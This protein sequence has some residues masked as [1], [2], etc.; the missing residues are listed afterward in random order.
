MVGIAHPVVPEEPRPCG[1][2]A[3]AGPHVDHP[4]RHAE[5]ARLGAGVLD[6]HV[7]TCVVVHRGGDGTAEGYMP[8]AGYPDRRGGL[9]RA[10]YGKV[11]VR[12]DCRRGHG[13]T[14]GQDCARATAVGPAAWWTRCC[15]TDPSCRPGKPPCPRSPTTSSWALRLQRVSAWPAAS[16]T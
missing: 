5:A 9:G 2:R 8:G 6:H 15:V 16:C 14:P 12:E 7:G 1:R 3:A 10:A 13:E 4:Q 11:P